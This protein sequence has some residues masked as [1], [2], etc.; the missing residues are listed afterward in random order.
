MAK[1]TGPLMSLSASG[2]VANTIVF[3]TWKGRPYVREHVVPHNPKTAG[4]IGV[5]ANFAGCVALYKALSDG[6][7]ALW[8]AQGK[9]TS[10]TGLN[11]MIKVAQKNL[12]MAKGIPDIPDPVPATVPGPPAIGLSPSVA[13]KQ[14]TLEWMQGSGGT[15]YTFMLHRSKSA[16][17]T[18][19]PSNLIGLYSG[20]TE[21]A[22][23]TPGV[24][25]WHY[26][27]VAGGTDGQLGMASTIVSAV[28][29]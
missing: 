28:V 1:V 3:S 18:P 20:N 6:N 14:V 8:T 22:N 19:V 27:L 21:Q 23:D 17:F 26:L 24:G 2:T 13:G 9:I 7:K 15:P 16:Q 29:S 25:T 4:Q 5:R 10:T 11:A 12:E